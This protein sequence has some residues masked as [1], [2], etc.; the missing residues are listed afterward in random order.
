MDRSRP[1]FHSSRQQLDV[2]AFYLAE[3]GSAILRGAGCV[4]GIEGKN[5]DSP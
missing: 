3:H 2:N 5:F 1:E 4:D